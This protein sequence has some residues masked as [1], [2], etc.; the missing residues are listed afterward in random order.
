MPIVLDTNVI[1]SAVTDRNAS[2][3][4]RAEHLIRDAASG[5]ESLVLP[6]FV[7][8]ETHYVLRNLYARPESEIA[9][10]LQDLIEMPGL[11]VEQTI[12]LEQLFELWPSQ[13]P[14]MA[15]AALA[16]VA[17]GRGCSVATF[18]A[19]LTRRLRALGVAV[20]SP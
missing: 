7:L 16:S 12:P 13:I 20:W 2:Q 19:S 11:D 10:L 8:F 18:D 9:G 3:R 6:Q 1:L 17:V 4:K 5:R 14:E 15:D